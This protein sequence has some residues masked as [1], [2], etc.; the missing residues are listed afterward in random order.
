MYGIYRIR[1]TTYLTAYALGYKEFKLDLRMDSSIQKTTDSVKSVGATE[2]RGDVYLTKSRHVR[3]G[4]EP[5][6][7][8]A[9][10]HQKY[11]A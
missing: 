10:R 6:S 1:Q 2:T 4:R 9:S 5:L 8:P 11:Q 3:F 7:G